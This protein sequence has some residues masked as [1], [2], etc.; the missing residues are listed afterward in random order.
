MILEML[1]EANERKMNRLK[2]MFTP[3]PIRFDLNLPY[4]IQLESKIQIG[5][6]K[7]SFDLTVNKAKPLC[8]GK[9]VSIGQINFQLGGNFKIYRFYIQDSENK[10]FILQVVKDLDTNENIETLL[11]NVVNEVFPVSVPDWELWLNRDGGLL[12]FKDFTLPTGEMFVRSI[13]GGDDD[14]VAP[15]EVNEQIGIDPFVHDEYS[16]D[17]DM[18][19]YSRA[20]DEENSEYCIISKETEKGND[21]IRILKGVEFDTDKI[22]VFNLN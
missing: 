12:G 18:V 21:F 19:F 4:D 20:I 6:D 14:K 16:V 2:S 11:F 3:K 7:P 13:P 8:S 1:K 5:G 17:H 9:V 15:I 22:F 10:E